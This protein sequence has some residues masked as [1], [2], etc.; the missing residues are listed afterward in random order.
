MGCKL[1]LHDLIPETLDIFFSELHKFVIILALASS[2]IIALRFAGTSPFVTIP[3]LVVYHAL[4]PVLWAGVIHIAYCNKMGQPCS[5]FA[6]LAKGFEVY[7][8]VVFAIINIAIRLM[9]VLIALLIPAVFV[10]ALVPVLGQV[11]IILPLLFMSMRYLLVI[12]IIVVEGDDVDAML[13]SYALTRSRTGTIFY[14]AL[15]FI[16]IPLIISMFIDIFVAHSGAKLHWGW[17]LLMNSAFELLGFAFAISVFLMY[18]NLHRAR[19][20][21][22]DM[23]EDAAPENDGEAAVSS[24]NE[25]FSETPET[26]DET[27]G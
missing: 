12:P 6:A 27:S 25:T 7:G 14:S 21:E 2:P 24:P 26:P 17:H 3:L 22:G 1:Y 20:D 13:K 4:M 19:R 8:L 11:V 9:L 10:A 18:L 23:V 15:A 5:I 16:A